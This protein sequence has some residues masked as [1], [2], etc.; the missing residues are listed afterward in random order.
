MNKVIVVHVFMWYERYEV[1]TF[2]EE[3]MFNQ[4]ALSLKILLRIKVFW[5]LQFSPTYILL[6]IVTFFAQFSKTRPLPGHCS[7]IVLYYMRARF[8]F[9]CNSL[10]ISEEHVAHINA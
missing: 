8:I 3:E 9:L 1:I 10:K 4:R 5:R 2:Y 7:E 6:Y